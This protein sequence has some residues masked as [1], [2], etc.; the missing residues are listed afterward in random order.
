MKYYGEDKRISQQIHIHSF[1][2]SL[3]FCTSALYLAPFFIHE[4]DKIPALMKFKFCECD[5]MAFSAQDPK[6]L[7]P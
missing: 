6:I 2:H 1:I 4:K 3:N 5:H 7:L